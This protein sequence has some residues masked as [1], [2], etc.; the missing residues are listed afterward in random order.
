MR[1]EQRADG[2]PSTSIAGTHDLAV[3]GRPGLRPPPRRTAQLV[4]QLRRA[5]HARCLSTIRLANAECGYPSAES[6]IQRAHRR[7]ER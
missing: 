6:M 5:D 2:A 3:F 4:L 1:R 7:Q